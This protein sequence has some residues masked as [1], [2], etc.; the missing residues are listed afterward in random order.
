MNILIV[1]QY[2]WPENFRIN[3]LVQG[4][5]ERGHNV[6]VLT[7]Q[8]N[9]PS[10]QFFP[11]YGWNGPKEEHLSGARILRVPLIP[12]GKG[13]NLHLILNYLSFVVTASWGVFFRMG[14]HEHFDAIFV[15]QTSPVTVGF[16]AALAKWRYKAPILFWVLD[17]WPE[18]LSA[19]GAI[20]S[21]LILGLVKRGVRW[22]YS[23]CSRVLVQSRA[24][25]T[26]VAALG[27]PLDKIMYFPNWMEAEYEAACHSKKPGNKNKPDR[28]SEFRI[29]FAGNIGAAQDFPAILD[30]AEIVA[31][32]SPHVQWIIAGDGRMAPWVKSE[33][34]RRNLSKHFSFLGQLPSSAMPEIFSTA[35]ALLVTLRSAPIFSLTI[36]GKVQSYLSAGKPLLA[37]LDGEGARVITE[38]G[39]GT[40]CN[41]GDSNTLAQNIAKLAGLSPE[42]RHAMGHKGRAY[43][44]QEFGRN[45]LFNRLES[46]I[47][48]V[49][50]ECRSKG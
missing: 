43:A 14:R 46:W 48:E 25:E 13:G 18:S 27:V 49:I 45:N 12:R 1:S 37:M 29:V 35:D 34:K 7:G 3:D 23:R 5:G 28:A 40:T 47:T 42:Q 15:F 41:A 4:L 6:T 10:G 33:V 44:R 38:S 30:A 17:L 8:P 31:K 39:G 19:T 32:E 11:G 20:R 2:F 24:F 36:P 22:I 21:P 26:N 9:Y 16:P 50:E